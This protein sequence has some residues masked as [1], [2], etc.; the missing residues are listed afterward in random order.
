MEHQR[1]PP[2]YRESLAAAKLYGDSMN[3]GQVFGS[4]SSQDK[5]FVE[6]L[7]ADLSANAIPAWYDKLDLGVG[8]SVPCRINDGLTK[9]RYFLI[10]LS[11][12]AL[13]SAWVREELN[14]GLMKHVTLGSTFVT[15]VLYKD[16]K[17]P[18]L[19]AHRRYADFRNDYTTGLSD[20]LAVWG[21]DSQ[22]FVQPQVEARSF[23][24]LTQISQTLNLFTCTPPASTNSFGGA[25]HF[26]GRQTRCWT[27]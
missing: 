26:L 1:P 27:T 19:L 25:V 4:H 5:P 22:A 14:A 8:E 12:A 2:G 10:V 15:P 21:K 9:S 24:G 18:P 13:T 17:V 23:H 7:V 6:K 11:P 16:C 20:L 3:L